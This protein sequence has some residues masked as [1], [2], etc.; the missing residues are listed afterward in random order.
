MSGLAHHLISGPAH[1]VTIPAVHSRNRSF[2]KNGVAEKS[3]AGL[4]SLKLTVGGIWQCERPKTVL[5]KLATPAA[6]SR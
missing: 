3:I 4:G 1:H 6:V 5:M 2:T